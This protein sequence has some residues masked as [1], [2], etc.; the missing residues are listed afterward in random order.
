VAADRSSQA[1]TERPRTPAAKRRPRTPAAQ[2]RR[3]RPREVPHRARWALG[4]WTS[5]IRDP[6]DVMR[7]A[8][9]VGAIVE[10]ALGNW[11]ASLRLALTFVAVLLARLADMPRPVD[12]MFNIGMALQAWG[13]VG[14][15]FREVGWY[16]AVVH[17]FL[18]FGTAALLYLLLIRLRVVPDLSEEA[19]LHRRAGIVIVAFAFGM[20]IGALYEMYEWFGYH[21]FGT[22]ILRES[23]TKM[24]TDLGDD[25]LGSLAGGALLVVWN[26]YGWATRRRLPASELAD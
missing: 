26:V 5:V 3:A 14:G 9:L 23:W 20:T 2:P 13:N 7:A 19:N 16:F 12:L 10:A 17:F 25:A 4:D 6:I 24:V 22:R 8:L 18:P 1:V 11:D 15:A 21:A